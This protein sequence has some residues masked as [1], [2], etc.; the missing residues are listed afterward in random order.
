MELKGKYKIGD[1]VWTY[2][3]HFD[4]FMR[5]TIECSKIVDGQ[6]MYNGMYP[7]EDCFSNLDDSYLHECDY[8]TRL[9]LERIKLLQK[10]FT[11]TVEEQEEDVKKTI[12]L[13]FAWR[14]NIN[15]REDN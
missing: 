13:G 5:I 4:E 6:I 11:K 8:Q 7:E 2:D 15:N 10:K 3:Y 12:Q 14:T 9:Y 1:R